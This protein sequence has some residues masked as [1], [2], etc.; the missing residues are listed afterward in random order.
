MEA[1]LTYTG[2][3]ALLLAAFYLFYK[4]LLSRETFHRMNRMILVGTLLV[5]ALLPFCVVTLHRTVEVPDV[6]A[7]AQS[8]DPNPASNTLAETSGEAETTMH[9]NP[10]RTAAPLWLTILFTIYVAG[11]VIAFS[12]TAVSAFRVF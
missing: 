12:R 1:L 6:I 3:V 5:A 11:V 4:W 8:E 7:A 10:S 2:K 9:G